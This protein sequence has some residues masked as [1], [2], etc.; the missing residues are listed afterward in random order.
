MFKTLNETI[1]VTSSFFRDQVT[2]EKFEWNGKQ[3]IVKNSKLIHKARKGAGKMFF[4]DVQDDNNLFKLSFDTK[5]LEWELNQVY[6]D[7]G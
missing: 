3:Y 1:K 4:F 5:S 6:I 7:K 2:P